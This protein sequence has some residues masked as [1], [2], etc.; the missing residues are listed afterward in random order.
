MLMTDII[1][2]RAKTI[3]MPKCYFYVKM[4]ILTTIYENSLVKLRLNDVMIKEKVK[5][6][7]EPYL[8]LCT[9]GQTA[10]T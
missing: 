6:S 1:W 3:R 7:N 8:F 10:N 4:A 2:K 9:D 5:D